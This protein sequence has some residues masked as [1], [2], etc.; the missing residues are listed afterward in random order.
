[1]YGTEL[2][3]AAIESAVKLFGI[4]AVNQ[5]LTKHYRSKPEDGVVPG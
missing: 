1:M 5:V 4:Q 3:G 2:F